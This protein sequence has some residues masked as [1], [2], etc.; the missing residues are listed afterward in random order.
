MPA[1][2]RGPSGNDLRGLRKSLSTKIV[3]G[4]DLCE[5]VEEILSTK[6]IEE[7]VSCEQIALRKVHAVVEVSTNRRREEVASTRKE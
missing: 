7:A 1:R 3:E 6:I 5:H 2:G 4:N